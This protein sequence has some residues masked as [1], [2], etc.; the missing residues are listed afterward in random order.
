M[1][2]LDA[3]FRK[4][5]FKTLAEAGY[6]KDEAQKI[7]GQ[8]YYNCLHE[9]VKKQLDLLLNDILKENYDVSVNGDEI[10]GKITELKKLKEFLKP[11]K[12]E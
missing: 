8:K 5:L 3:D 4:N 12:T 11:T 6:D 2:I 10:N 9:D 1:K 7:V